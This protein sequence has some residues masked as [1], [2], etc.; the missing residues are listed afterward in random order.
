MSEQQNYS[1][2]DTSIAQ[3]AKVL[4]VAILT[5]TDITDNLR[6]MTLTVDSDTGNLVPCEEYTKSFNQNIEQMLSE[7]QEDESE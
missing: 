2:S 3:I 7:V 5:G 6:Q 4:Q 1:L